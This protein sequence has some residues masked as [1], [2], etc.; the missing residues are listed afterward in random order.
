MSMECPGP[1]NNFSFNLECQYG[2]GIF[3][4]HPPKILLHYGLNL[5]RS[6]SIHWHELVLMQMDHI[7]LLKV[8]MPYDV[9]I[10]R[11]Q[12]IHWHE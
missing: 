10:S 8:L 6:N 4:K 1:C 7:L 11:S 12:S 5:C 9:R 3:L 2:N